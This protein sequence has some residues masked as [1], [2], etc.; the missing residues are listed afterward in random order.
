[1]IDKEL[2]QGDPTITIEKEICSSCLLGKQ[3]RRMFPLEA[4]FRAVRKP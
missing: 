4:T 1:M 3:T 2:V